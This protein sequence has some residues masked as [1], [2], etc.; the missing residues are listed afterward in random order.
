MPIPVPAI[1]I[2]IAVVAAMKKPKQ[3]GMTPE[4]K[5]VYETA[6]RELKDPIGLRK[7]A[8]VFEEQGLNAEADILRK[9]AKLR[10]LPKE[11]KDARRAVFRKAMASKN[12]DAVE[13]VARAYY[14]EGC[15]AASA[16]LFSYAKG[17][18]AQPD[19]AKV[20][21]ETTLPEPE[22]TK[23][24]TKEESKAEET[25]EATAEVVH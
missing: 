22:E 25:T 20:P 1:V 13:T 6:L 23:E 8:D 16:K 5:V 2:G 9:R 21:E 18:R 10:E 12:P 24:E 7:L 19:T 15:A 4:R 11:V 14:N 17:L 3:V